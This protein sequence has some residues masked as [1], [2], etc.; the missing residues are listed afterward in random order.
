VKGSERFVKEQV[1]PV[2]PSFTILYNRVKSL[3]FLFIS[4]FLT[5]HQRGIDQEMTLISSIPHASE[6]FATPIATFEETPNRQ[7][8]T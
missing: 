4:L 7:K 5:P 6:V 3:E 1:K 8:I 2:D